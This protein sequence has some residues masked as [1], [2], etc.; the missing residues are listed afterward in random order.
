[1]P[2]LG[3]FAESIINPNAV[4]DS[5][6]KEKGYLYRLPQGRDEQGTLKPLAH[7]LSYIARTTIL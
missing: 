3:L 4:I 7:Q 1:M 2:R 6:D 5:D